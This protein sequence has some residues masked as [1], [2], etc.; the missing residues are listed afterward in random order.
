MSLL[1]NTAWPL[2]DLAASR[3]AAASP[4]TTVLQHHRH[5]FTFPPATLATFALFAALTAFAPF[6]PLGTLAI[7]ATLAPFAP[8]APLTTL[9]ALATLADPAASAVPAAYSITSCFQIHVKRFH[10][11]LFFLMPHPMPHLV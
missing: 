8:F 10:Q 5:G 7:L 3:H 2:Q 11:P 4:F 1:L 9:A 6:A